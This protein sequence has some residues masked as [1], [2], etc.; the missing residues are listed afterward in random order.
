VGVI[1]REGLEGGFGRRNEMEEER[2]AES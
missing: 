1:L 2:C